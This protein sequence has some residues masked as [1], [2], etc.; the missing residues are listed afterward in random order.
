MSEEGM[1]KFEDVCPFPT[2][3]LSYSF[4]DVESVLIF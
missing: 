3:F 1:I 4:T 2:W